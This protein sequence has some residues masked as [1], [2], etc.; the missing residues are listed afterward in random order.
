MSDKSWS[1]HSDGDNTRKNH[2]N[3]ITHMQLKFAYLYLPVECTTMKV[4]LAIKTND[5]YGCLNCDILVHLSE[6]S[7]H[8]R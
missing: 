1:A 4:Y 2:L 5:V 8:Q 7:P 3:K 6:S